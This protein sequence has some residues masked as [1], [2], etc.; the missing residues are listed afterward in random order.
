LAPPPTP[1][2]SLP[3]KIKSD[4]ITQAMSVIWPGYAE[5]PFDAKMLETT[6]RT[7]RS[8]PANDLAHRRVL[9][10]L[11]DAAPLADLQTLRTRFLI[12]PGHAD[13]IAGARVKQLAP[14]PRSK[15]GTSTALDTAREDFWG[16][17]LTVDS[18]LFFSRTWLDMCAAYL[19][20]IVK[21]RTSSTLPK[22]VTM[23][24]ARACYAY[25]MLTQPGLHQRVGPAAITILDTGQLAYGFAL[26]M[27]PR[28][29]DPRVVLERA[30]QLDRLLL[31]EFR[32]HPSRPASARS[33]G[34]TGAG[35]P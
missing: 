22:G 34:P 20:V 10:K 14:A 2:P 23:K 26:E 17:A 11:G 29:S 32:A 21:A 15:P 30:R 19:A 28:G 18:P 35:R 13:M 25:L 8:T 1:Q 33:T 27:D 16:G 12:H 31:E 4:G 9:E 6:Q 3:S 7:L 5:G 24:E